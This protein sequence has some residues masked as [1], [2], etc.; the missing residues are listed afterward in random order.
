MTAESLS[1]D[2][3]A[4]ERRERP[5]PGLAYF[6]A[7]DRHL[8]FG[9][10]KDVS[11]VVARIRSARVSVL[12]APSGVG[13]TSLVNAEVIPTLEMKGVSTVRIELQN[14]PLH[15]TKVA[16]LEYLLPPP[17]LECS[18]L[19]QARS[20]LDLDGSATLADLVAVHGKL[21][22][23]DRRF[24]QL[25]RSIPCPSEATDGVLPEGGR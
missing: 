13:K 12:H 4:E 17:S 15:S 19:Q 7:E 20:S 3:E 6:E 21:D 5:Y 25:I 2:T 11:Q 8:F 23:G 9:R 16:S 24:R 10:D 1:R 22:K 18:A 14:N